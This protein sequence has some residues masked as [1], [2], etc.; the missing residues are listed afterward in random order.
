MSR[1][2]RIHL[3]TDERAQKYTGSF[4]AEKIHVI[5]AASPS[6]KNPF[7]MAM[8]AIAL[9]KGMRSSRILLKQLKP[10][11]V[12]GFGG[13]PTV[14]PL[15]A[16]SGSFP[17]MIHEQNAV[18]GRANKMLAGRVTAIAGG[19]LKAEGELADRIVE[20]GNPIRPPVIAASKKPYVKI[21]P[22]SPI[23]LVV[24][25]GSQGAQ[26][27][28]KVLPEALSLMGAEIQQRLVLTQQ[29]RPEDEAA[30]REAYEKLGIEADVSPFFDD[31]PDRI[32]D[33]HLV[34]ARSGASTVSEIAAIG[35]P[36]IFVPYPFALDHDQAA[37][38]EALERTGGAIVSRQDDLGAQALADELTRLFSTPDQLVQMAASAKAAGKPH[39]VTLL[40]DLT[41]AIASGQQI[42][43]FK[44]A[45]IDS[46]AAENPE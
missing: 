10:G 23:R 36:A 2:W 29:A 12:I 21:S 35:R 7:K 11:V 24:F 8:A 40:A 6:G 30:A 14:P 19:F 1:G 26:Y 17:T 9:F 13:Y 20:T 42:A 37:N 32:A 33:A 15:V 16:A 44:S 34:I 4:P 28:S 5:E 39:A 45:H 43:D 41:E 25:G 22:D 27:F 46:A 3:A 38:A 31:L 18:A